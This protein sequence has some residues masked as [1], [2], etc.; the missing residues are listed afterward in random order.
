MP[1]M[2][3]SSTNFFQISFRHPPCRSAT[4]CCHGAWPVTREHREPH[5]CTAFA[6]SFANPPSMS[7][8]VAS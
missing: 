7:T 3:V 6:K 1:S 4:P 2:P 5:A 8:W